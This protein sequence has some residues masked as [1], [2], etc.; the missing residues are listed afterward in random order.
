MKLNEMHFSAAAAASNAANN[1]FS[2]NRFLP[3]NLISDQ[4]H[5]GGGLHYDY[6]NTF[7][8][9][10]DSMYYPPPLYPAHANHL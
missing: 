4:K 3:G 6:S 1:P 10:H 8:S 5:D 2:I 9:H 7:A